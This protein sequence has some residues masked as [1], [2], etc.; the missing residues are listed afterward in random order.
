MGARS[1]TS[2]KSVAIRWP[3]PFQTCTTPL[4][5]VRLETPLSGSPHR[6]C[7]TQSGMNARNSGR[8]FAAGGRRHTTARQDAPMTDEPLTAPGTQVFDFHGGLSLP[9]FR[10]AVSLHAHTRHSNE[11]LTGVPAYLNRIPV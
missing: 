11:V 3:Q 6:C 4:R 9:Q 5:T 1:S 10:T 8:V 2:P 7:G